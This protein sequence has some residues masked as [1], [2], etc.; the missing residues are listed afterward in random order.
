MSSAIFGGYFLFLWGCVRKGHQQVAEHPNE[1]IRSNTMT[2]VN[3]TT[4]TATEK[5]V[6]SV[7]SSVHAGHQE[8]QVQ[9]DDQVAAQQVTMT[10]T[11]A[12][13]INEA[14][15]Q[16]LEQK[17]KETIN[18]P[19]FWAKDAR[20]DTL[21]DNLEV[22]MFDDR[23]L[24]QYYIHATG[25]MNVAAAK[26][27]DR[28]KVPAVLPTEAECKAETWKRYIVKVTATATKTFKKDKVKATDEMIQA[29]VQVAL[30][31]LSDKQEF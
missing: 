23:S 29:A 22:P 20:F 5:I 19:R 31:K 15:K 30:D 28:E 13:E 16:E 26:L 9:Q 11:A 2:T 1:E 10:T 4:D 12:I 14:K 24:Q 21:M 27:S 18:N 8:V 6:A 3:P 7:L 25:E 17:F